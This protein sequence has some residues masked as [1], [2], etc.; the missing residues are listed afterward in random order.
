[1]TRITLTEAKTHM[2]EI[3]SRTEFGGER[4][5]VQRRGKDAVVL[6]PAK[7]FALY[8]RWLD[9]QEDRILGDKALAAESEGQYL[10][11]DQVKD[12]L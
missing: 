4:I 9:E 8:E 5:I 12:S 3:M 11:W 1:M 10:S 7:E 2:G 6:I